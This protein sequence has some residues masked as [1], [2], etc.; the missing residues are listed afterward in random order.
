MKLDD[1]PASLQACRDA[2]N[3]AFAKLRS[4]TAEVLVKANGGN[5][6]ETVAFANATAPAVEDSLRELM[7]VAGNCK[8]DALQMHPSPVTMLSPYFAIAP[9]CL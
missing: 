9:V 3:D 2:A 4:A 1:A 8:R 7:M 6:V 5:N